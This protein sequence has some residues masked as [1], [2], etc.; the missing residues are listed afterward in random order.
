[1][2]N[3]E[4]FN[5]KNYINGKWLVSSSLL[6]VSNPA[7]DKVIG[8]VPNLN[9]SEV[10]QAI[11]STAEGFIIWSKSTIKER[12]DFL[13]N[14]YQLIVKNVD[15]LAYI[16]TLE[17]GKII[18]DAKAEVLY[19][20][21]FV[22]WFALS[23]MTHS[24]YIRI[25]N[26]SSH[27]IIT[28]HEPIGP[29]AAITPWNFPLAMVTRK[30]A[31]ALAAGCSILL[32]PS[33][34]TPFS[35]LMLV[36][37]AEQA[38]LPAGVFNVITGEAALI[39]KLI[40]EDFRIRKLS[41]TGSTEI[42]K[43]L[44]AQSASSLKKLSL[45]LGGNAPFIILNDVNI[46]QVTDDL[47]RAKTRSNGQSCTSP[48]RI[49]IHQDIYNHFVDVLSA[50]FSKLK[51]GNGLD[52]DI[53]LGPLINKK[54]CHH[55]QSLLED[56]TKHGAN[57]LCGGKFKD[58]FFEPTVVKNCHDGMQIFKAEIFGP[59]LACYEF[60]E[61]SALIQSANNTEYGLQAYIYTKD[62]SLAQKITADLDFGMVSVNSAS[63]SNTKAPFG[64]RKA[65]GFG[66][67]GS[68]EGLLEYMNIKYINMQY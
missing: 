59:V 45:E 28:E 44:Y 35:A 50:K 55:V 15:E 11:D 30:A 3:L 68:H 33:S 53:C 65:S 19:A 14:W 39:G 61:I 64:G 54:A 43:T 13:T 37:L 40:C 22:E 62:I 10:K 36:F 42:G 58:N 9:S 23:L 24:S 57:I 41:F 18:S 1:M 20:A 63:A 66:I 7:N 67:E 8:Y 12:Y 38:K 47:I 60:S 46:E 31:P 27:K 21:S 48:N 25:G 56:A 51:I 52:A 16:L 5:N 26:N 32:K 4:L 6:P 17:Q 34:Q 2:N 49:Y 29:V